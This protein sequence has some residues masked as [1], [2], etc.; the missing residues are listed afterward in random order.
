[1]DSGKVKQ[2]CIAFDFDGTMCR[3]FKNYDLKATAR[4]LSEAV[5]KFGVD[6]DCALDAFEVFAEIA[7]QTVA[8]ETREAAYRESDSILTAAELEAV[9]GA[10]SVYGVEE[11]FAKLIKRGVK[12]GVAT[13][14]SAECVKAF[15]ERR[16]PEAEVPVAGR[17]PAQPELMKPHTHSLEITAK[18]LNCPLKDL[19]FIGDT[20]RDYECAVNAGCEFLGIAPTP[21]KRKRLSAFLPQNK[22]VSDYY[23]LA[24][25]L[26]I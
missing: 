23:E 17:E 3:V 19:L 9:A 2:I 5:K 21:L 14:N 22:I 18:A 25:L 13:N 8:G 26:S 4:K 16:I 20:Q 15:L 7:R 10:E 6:F 24:A 12:V 1:M 11:V